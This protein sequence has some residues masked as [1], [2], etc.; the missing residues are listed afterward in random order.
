MRIIEFIFPKRHLQQT[1]PSG[2]SSWDCDYKCKVA[3][4]Q[5]FSR[6]HI[7]ITSCSAWT[8]RSESADGRVLIGL[9]LR[10]FAPSEHT[11]RN[12][13][14]KRR[15]FPTANMTA[16]FA[17]LTSVLDAKDYLQ[18]QIPKSYNSSSHSYET[19][20]DSRFARPRHC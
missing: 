6:L 3:R 20:P 10:G 15:R 7:P 16:L 11:V 12:S 17:A 13:T 8:L 14:T 5:D 19:R 2:T 4:P 1:V 9:S 18:V